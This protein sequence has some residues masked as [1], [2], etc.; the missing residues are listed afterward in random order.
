MKKRMPH[1]DVKEKQ[2]EA[3]LVCFSGFISCFDC[4]FSFLVLLTKA[5]FKRLRGISS[6]LNQDPPSPQIVPFIEASVG[7]HY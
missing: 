4:L 1:V 3:F 6:V 2:E 5:K 7:S